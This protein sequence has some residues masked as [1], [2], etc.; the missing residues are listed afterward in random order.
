MRSWVRG[1]AHTNTASWWPVVAH[2]GDRAADVPEPEHAEGERRE[3]TVS[4]GGGAWLVTRAEPLGALLPL[5]QQAQLT[6]T[7][8][9]VQ[10]GVL[11]HLRGRQ[12]KRFGG[13]RCELHLPLGK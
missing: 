13:E 10:R 1:L 8:E 11:G 9:N 3:A 7:P 4:P 12:A 2:T 5:P 6:L